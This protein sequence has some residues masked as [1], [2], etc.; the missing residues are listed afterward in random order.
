LLGFIVLVAAGW[1]RLTG[2]VIR[3]AEARDFAAMAEIEWAAGEQFRAL[4]MDSIADDEP[5]SS[6]DLSLSLSQGPCWVWVDESD[7]AIAYLVSFRMGDRLFIEQVTV[8]PDFSRRGIGASLI[9]AAGERA[10]T[11]GM[12]GLPLTTFADVPWNAPYY[13][14]LGFRVIPESQWSSAMR[15]RVLAEA[16]HG[17]DTW[18]RV[19]MVR[20]GNS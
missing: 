1:V 3:V 4:G 2:V 5:P 18:P 9:A 12:V 20:D 15:L 6:T 7:L 8:H 17:L 13:E 19:V 10:E 14:R 11:D 16:A